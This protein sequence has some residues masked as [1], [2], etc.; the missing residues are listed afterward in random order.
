MKR[1]YKHKHKY[2]GKHKH[3]FKSDK[4]YTLK[5]NINHVNLLWIGCHYDTLAYAH[6]IN[7]NKHMNIPNIIKVYI[8]IFWYKLDSGVFY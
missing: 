6:F 5:I 8:H 2:K 7:W 1:K 3:E 4:V